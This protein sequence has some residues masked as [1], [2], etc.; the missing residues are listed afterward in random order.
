MIEESERYKSL[1]SYYLTDISSKISS[2]I[3][4]TRL[5]NA[6]IKRI[7]NAKESDNYLDK[8]VRQKTITKSQRSVYNEILV[9]THFPELV[10]QWNKLQRAS[11]SAFTKKVK[12]L[13]F[14]HSTK[15]EKEVVMSPLDSVKYHGQHLHLGSISIEPGT[16]HVKTWV[17]GIGYKY[18]QY[19]HINTSRQVGSTFK[20]F[21][22]AT[23]MMDGGNSP[24]LKVEDKQYCIEK[25]DPFFDVSDRWCPKNSNNTYTGESFTLFDGMR[26]SK[27]T[28]SAYLMK[29]IGGVQPVIR[30]V[31]K[32]G[33]PSEKIPPYPSIA[34]G[35][36]E[37]SVMEM[38]SAYSVFANNGDYIEPTFIDRIEDKDGKLIYKANPERYQA[39][40][41]KYSYAM[42]EM[43]KYASSASFLQNALNTEFGGKTGT[44]DD[45][46]DGWY[47][48][49]MPNLVV[50]TWVG[51]NS[52]WVRFNSLSDGAGGKMAR[53]FYLDFMKRVENDKSIKHNQNA[54]FYVPEGDLIVTD[55]SLYENLYQKPKTIV[56][57]EFD[58]EFDEEF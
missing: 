48:G 55:C 12:M 17:G 31:E 38:T 30:F 25:N 43:L 13:V 29:L 40:P 16:G 21:I 10:N 11:K 49:I 2:D 15:G 35:T 58:E 39:L 46:T 22:Y 8:L 37:L 9:S 42:V 51:G 23:A 18:F 24:C 45:H 27:N 52:A 33:I 34:L 1:R 6:D 50:G 4:S 36:P 3:K 20:P 56:E 41:E 19:D 32:L 28:V 7:L 5:W 54:T 53:P 26:L 14:D 57:E 44:T 47:M